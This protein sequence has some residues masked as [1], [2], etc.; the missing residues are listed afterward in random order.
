MYSDPQG[1]SMHIQ[2]QVHRQPPTP[3]VQEQLL[4]EPL[5]LPLTPLQ[6]LQ[7]QPLLQPHR[8]QPQPPLQPQ[9]LQPQPLLTPATA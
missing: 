5:E 4:S 2:S 3:Q 9:R 1:R 6:E 8:L 7:P